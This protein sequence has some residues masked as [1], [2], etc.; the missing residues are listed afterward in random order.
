MAARG[1]R[2]GRTG[3]IALALPD[4]S[5]GYSATVVAAFVHA[6]KRRGWS[7][8]VE[9]T[10]DDPGR[11]QALLTRAREQQVDGLVLNPVLLESSALRRPQSL[12][13]LV[14]IGEVDQPAV[15]HVWVDNPAAFHTLVTALARAGRRRIAVLG[16][17][18]SASSQLRVAGYH[19]A[20]DDAGLPRDPELEIATRDW[21]AQGGHE[22]ITRL[23]ARGSTPPDAVVGLTD[24]LALGAIGALLRHGLDVP[25]QVAV[26]GYDDLEVARWTSPSLTS[27]SFDRAAIA[28]AALDLLTARIRQ[29]G[30]PVDVRVVPHRVVVRESSG[31]LPLLPG[32]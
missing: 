19:R 5:T 14:L 30:A 8:H 1:L 9:E 10:G 6:A 22:A 4:L 18:H 3:V 25:G 23:L 15:D 12:P 16:V 29:P 7:I 21:S 11:E 17:M 32:P 2:N 31:P 20:L 13:P 26:C 28:E 27:V 24:S